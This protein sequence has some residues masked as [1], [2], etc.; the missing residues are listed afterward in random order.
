MS[1]IVF[2]FTSVNSFIDTYA[3]TFFVPS[4]F[5]LFVSHTVSEMKGEVNSPVLAYFQFHK[6][7]SK[8]A[9]ILMASFWVHFTCLIFIHLVMTSKDS[10]RFSFEGEK[11]YLYI[12]EI[13]SSSY[14]L[15]S[16][17][18]LALISQYCHNGIV[19]ICAKL[20]LISLAPSAHYISYSNI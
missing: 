17:Y 6:R 1:I 18:E 10:E 16:K 9:V 11:W 7:R 3:I 5:P 20:V 12:R 8:G 4:W 14:S 2:L 13:F 19:M 15:F